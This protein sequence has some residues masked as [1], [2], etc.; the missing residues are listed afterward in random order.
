MALVSITGLPVV[1]SGQTPVGTAF[2]QQGNIEFNGSPVNGVAD[3]RF[4]AWDLDNNGMQVGPQVDVTAD[5]VDGFYAAYIDFGP[6]P[7][8]TNQARWLEI[9]VRFPA[10]SGSFVT[11]TPRQRITATP[12]STATRG[13]TVDGDGDVGIGTD[14]PGAKLE[15]AGDAWIGGSLRIGTGTACFTEP[16]NS[17]NSN[18][19]LDINATQN[20]S[21]SVGALVTTVPCTAA[22]AERALDLQST[23]F[24]DTTPATPNLLGG[25]GGNHVDFDVL[26]GISTYGASIGGGGGNAWDPSTM[27][28]LGPVPNA[29]YDNYGTVGGGR[30][31]VTGTQDN[32]I[33][34]DGEYA[35][36]CGGLNNTSEGISCAIGGGEQNFAAGHSDPSQ[37]VGHNTVGGGWANSASGARCTVGGGL[38]N[39]ANG[40][41]S[42]VGGGKDNQAGPNTWSLK[43]DPSLFIGCATVAG[44]CVNEATA[45]DST[46]G[47][48]TA[49]IA[50]GEK[51]TISGGAGNVAFGKGS[52]VG[53]GA[54]N[55]AGDSTVVDPT[56]VRFAMVP[57]GLD[58]E[59]KGRYSLAA[60]RRAKALHT[61]TFVWGDST[62]AD[63][64]SLDVD[65]YLIRAAG[66]VGIGTNDPA[67]QLHVAKDSDPFITFEN[68]G[69]TSTIRNIS[70]KFEH[71][72]TG[73]GAEIKAS[74]AAGASN[75]MD[76]RFST[77]PVG[78]TLTERMRITPDGAVGI[79]TSNPVSAAK[80]HVHGPLH[81]SG[82]SEDIG[83]P[84]GDQMQFGHRDSTD[85][86][87]TERMRISS[88]GNVGIGMTPT[89]NRLEVNGNASKSTAGD[90]LANSDAS[91]KTQVRTVTDALAMIAR[92]RPVAFR[93]TE[94]YKARHPSVKDQDYFNYVAQE[95]REVFP[96]WVQDSGE[97]GLLQMDAYPASVYAVAAIQELDGIV[98]EKDCEIEELR[99]NNDHTV[100]EMSNLRSE[101][102]ELKT[103]VK[104][105]V[106]HNT[107]ESK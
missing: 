20:V 13:L 105:L 3:F 34:A 66:G 9:A 14:A 103:L 99:N 19:I 37:V 64:A 57:G 59:A 106:S 56:D 92:L 46:V 31:N 58:N 28:F 104:I 33:Y 83:V 36:V 53:G 7:F 41:H 24:L 1:V 87:F 93:Y 107:G 67:G 85:N 86:S 79:G 91:I 5:V 17:L 23:S 42:T 62:D 4:T 70:I 102:A 49:N 89:T 63:F 69:D 65:Q 45:N 78:L 39:L 73:T 61:G 95:F 11:L 6:G 40:C 80:L 71:D 29:V 52:T 25:Y 51:S 94:D 27:M 77:Q 55:I 38:S 100:Q 44:G 84:D 26:H 10:G 68:V 30:G 50:F 96:E 54:S 101:I 35:T 18:T 74:R 15:V 90:W 22:G 48:G 82:S 60:G 21:I 72:G 32:Y 81:L 8:S 88:A 2:T 12:F 47:G 75:G 97:D 16:G 43:Q 98:R 76:L